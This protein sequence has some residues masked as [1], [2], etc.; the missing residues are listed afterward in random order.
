MKLREAHK[1]QFEEAL[2]KLESEFKIMFP[3]LLTMLR[4]ETPV[5][6]SQAN[7]ELIGEKFF[8]IKSAVKDFVETLGECDIRNA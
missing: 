6:F 2:Y 8:A 7:T 4:D 5:D 3:M 1:L